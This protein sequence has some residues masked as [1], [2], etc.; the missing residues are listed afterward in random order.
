[1]KRFLLLGTLC[2]TLLIGG[3][4]ESLKTKGGSGS[5]VIRNSVTEVDPNGNT[6]VSNTETIF[7]V[8]QPD[9]P[10]KTAG[11][12]YHMNPDGS[13]DVSL[14]TGDSQNVASIAAGANLLRIPI[15]AG[16]A[17]IPIALSV[18]YF[19]RN[20]KWAGIIGATGIIMIAGS[21]ILSQ[22]AIY[23][24]GFLFILMVFGAYLLYDYYRQAKA[25]NENVLLMQKLRRDGAID[26]NKFK[27]AAEK[28]Q[29]KSTK[30]IVDRIKEKKW[31]G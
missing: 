26:L 27:E 1:M 31:N 13:T 16:I 3:C 19:T 14:T 28:T 23:F 5:V 21:Y 12:K 8:N 10:N 25:N 22:Y 7:D 4:N 17:L 11:I 18:G 6:K 24:L 20:L 29:S 2:L 30:K 15:Y 9:N